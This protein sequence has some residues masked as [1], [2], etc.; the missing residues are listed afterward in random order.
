MIG[1][2]KEPSPVLLVPL[3]HSE[4]A[5]DLFLILIA[6][7]SGRP[8]HIHRISLIAGDQMN[9]EMKYRLSGCF[10]VI[11]K[12]I[13]PV[14]VKA[15]L[16]FSSNH[17]CHARHLRRDVLRQLKEVRRVLLRKDQRVSL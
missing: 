3:T 17:R 2:I 5:K 1:S 9:M 10:P 7:F 13:Q 15:F 6:E 11:L 16:E 14:S 4:Q 8:G 12:D